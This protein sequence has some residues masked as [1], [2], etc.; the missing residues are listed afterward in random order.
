MSFISVNDQRKSF[1][2]SA[3]P[4]KKYVPGTR[5]LILEIKGMSDKINTMETELK[6]LHDQL[7]DTI[8]QDKMN[9]PKSKIMNELKV[10]IEEK[11]GLSGERKSIFDLNA[12]HNAEIEKL[13]GTK[14]GMSTMN[15]A[16]ISKTI[17]E[18]EMKLISSSLKPKEENE[19]SNSLVNLKLQKSK[20]GDIEAKLAQAR[21][22]EQSVKESKTRL[23]ELSKQLQAKNSQ[24]DDLKSQLD[25]LVE[26]AK[27]KSPA[28][29]KLETRIESLKNQKTAL[30][31][32]RLKKREELH[33]VEEDYSKLESEIL[34][35]KQLEEQK[36]SRRKIISDL[37]SEKDSLTLKKDEFDPKAFDLIVYNLEKLKLQ[38]A[39]DLS[40]DIGMVS[41]LLK[42][43]IK[44]P[45]T[46]E[47]LDSTISS[48][49]DKKNESVI[50]FAKSVNSISSSIEELNK[51]ISDEMEKLSLL[52]PTN[53]EL[54]KKGGF[55]NKS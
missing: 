32:D 28:I 13:R 34:L 22:L 24:I 10:A 36:D 26:S 55:R 53:F 8:Q 42:H 40:L 41:S 45:A 30:V 38:K 3:Q 9:S 27:T 37:R 4:P 18:L 11:K 23:T 43:G 2:G 14:D 35:Q 46:T 17:E 47:S 7:H 25:K 52:P 54:L 49:K 16:K 15:G 19:I 12:S 21:D 48:V 31:N 1:D 6:N 33:K 50:L 29:S 51:K 5:N 20:L 44:I 39:K